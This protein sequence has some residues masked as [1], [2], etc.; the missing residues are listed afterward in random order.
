MGH[1]WARTANQTVQATGAS[2]LART[3]IERH[4]RLAPV[5]DLYVGICNHSASKEP[6]EKSIERSSDE[7]A[8]IE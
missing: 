6:Y 2:R 4:R 5:P 1:W 7:K 3:Q 8:Q